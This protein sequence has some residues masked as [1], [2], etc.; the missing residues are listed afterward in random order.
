MRPIQEIIEELHIPSQYVEYYGRYSAKLRLELLDAVKDKPARGKLIMVT[1]VTPT[2]SGEGKTVTSIGLTQGIN[3]IGKTSVITSREPSLGPIF[4]IKGGATG[5]GGAQLLPADKINLHF[6]GDF[7]AITSAHNLLAALLDAHMFNGNLL[8][9][10]PSTITWPR[11]MDMND[12]ALRNIIVGMG[13]SN[14]PLRET[15]FVI[16]A[17]SEIMAILALCTS[18]EDLRARLNDIVVGFD[19]EG[20]VIRARDI[21]AAGAMMALLQDAIMPNLVQTIEG[22]PGFVH[23]GPF[24]NIAHGTSSVISHRMG[25]QLSDYVVN[26]SGFGA[27]LGAE[28]YFD[29]VMPKSGIKPAAAVVV[30]SI[31]A[32]AQ[33]N[34]GDVPPEA[35]GKHGDAGF[36]NLARHLENLRKF[37]VEPIVAINRFPQDTQAELD[38]VLDFCKEFKV[39]AAISEVVSAGGAGAADLAEKVCAAADANVPGKVKPLYSPEMPLEQKVETIAKSIYGAGKVIFDDVARRRLKKFATLGFGHLPVCIA[40][41]QYSFTDNP[42]ITGAPSGFTISITDAH[43]SAGAGFVVAI[44][45]NMML[46]PGLGKTPQAHHMDVDPQGNILGL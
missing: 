26:E 3:H 18:R 2:T 17:A 8:R 29:I 5:T 32:M 39:A 13:K 34:S 42:K 9:L 37:G 28:K 38:R 36:A 10:E 27:D 33:Q 43:L 1:A 7:H 14:G 16:T 25:L 30:A 15:G 45:G 41:T 44:A 19:H 22:T 11:C 24:G 6:N 12:R 40:K 23:C 20:K 21:Q 35:K 46:M 4:G 31:K